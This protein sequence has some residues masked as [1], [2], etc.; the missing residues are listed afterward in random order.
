MTTKHRQRIDVIR[1]ELH[2]GRGDRLYLYPVKLE[3]CFMPFDPFRP[4][5]GDRNPG[6][7]GHVQELGFLRV[8]PSDEDRFSADTSE[9]FL[10]SL[11]PSSPWSFEVVGIEGDVE[12]QLAVP[13]QDAGFA[14]GQ[15]EAHYPNCEVFCGPDLIAE[16]AGRLKIARGYRL[17][18]SH[19]FP[20]RDNH[21]T[22]PYAALI[23]VMGTIGSQDVTLFQ[24]L[25]T[26]VR[27]NWRSN[28]SRVARH[29]YD[30]S[31]SVFADVPQ[32]PKK[33]DD[34]TAK[35]LF[36]ASVR[37]AASDEELLNMIEGSFL[38]QF[39]SED[40]RLEKI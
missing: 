18:R 35:P 40:N 13:V 20:I 4:W 27:H 5:T 14:I 9:Q 8:R 36:V 31:K 39:D 7:D 17:R 3:P 32:L 38:S 2:T 28:I 34:K 16:I 22:D 37:M 15:I 19:L 29:P 25:F 12:I 10:L 30:T 24:V 21:R 1:Q 33:A 6:K 11:N 23:G 26:P